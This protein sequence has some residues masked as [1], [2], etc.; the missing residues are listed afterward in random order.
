MNS[1]ANNML[2]YHH[3]ANET[4][5]ARLREL[6][7]SVFHEETLSSYPTISATLGHLYVVD[8]M[9]YLVLNGM[10]MTEALQQSQPLLPLGS[11]WDLSECT[12]RLTE[13]AQQYVQWIEQVDLSQTMVVNNPYAGT[14]EL[15]L[16]ELV[17]HLVNHGTYHRGNITTMLRQLGYPSVMN[18]YILYLYQQP[19][20]TP[21]GSLDSV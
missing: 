21:S 19:Q 9:W 4:L 8:H 6:P 7:A 11:E 3:W 15:S 12:A 17:L 16:E 20:Q 1:T 2:R 5:L 14:R 10:E 18:D 13:Q